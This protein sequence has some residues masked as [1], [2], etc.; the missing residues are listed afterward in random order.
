MAAGFLQLG[1]DCRAITHHAAQLRQIVRTLNERRRHPVDADVETERE[2]PG[3]FF[4]ERRQRQH[5]VGH[6]DT[7]SIRQLAASDDDGAGEVIAALRDPQS[8]LA[9]I[10]K[11][12]RARLDC[13]EDLRVGQWRPR[14]V[15][16]FLVEIQA[17]ALA[18]DEGDGAARQLP[19][20]QLR[21]LQIQHDGDRPAR[22]PLQRADLSD[23]VLELCEGAVAAVEP[24]HVG[25]GFEELL[26]AFKGGAGGAECRDDLGVSVAAHGLRRRWVRGP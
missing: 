10:E 19:D 18:F 4:R 8:K 24:E 5:H 7:F 12:I 22:A 26:D 23:A 25:A 13:R 2:I 14:C 11:Q 3:I 16:G 20:A 9:V 1:E 15:T 6:V 17:I 21:P